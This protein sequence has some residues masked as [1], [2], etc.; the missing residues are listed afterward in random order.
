VSSIISAAGL[1]KE[2]RG[3]GSVAVDHI[4]FEVRDGECFGFLGPNGAGK[5]TTMRMIACRAQ[6]S[7]GDLTVMGLDPLRNERDIKAQMGVVPQE[8]NLDTVI[9]VEENLLMYARFFGIA[10][11]EGASRARELLE[12]VQLEDRADWHVDNLSGGMKRRLLIARSLV[13]RPRVIVLDEPTTGL[14]PQARHLVWER[15]RD[16]KRRGVTLVI[17]THYM[18][19]AAQLCD[20]LVIMHQGRILV[21]GSPTELIR[22]HVAPQVVELTARSHDALDV[23]EQEVIGFDVT[24]EVAGDRV[25]M[26]T[27]DGETLLKSIREAG[28]DFESATFRPANMEDVFL[29]MTGRRLE[30]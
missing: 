15:L 8:T 12:F 4:D 3:S 10:R 25:V 18:E 9:S 21:E 24:Y 20:R 13:N 16:L 19:E 22:R 11:S 2:Y 30:E 6:R 28:V 27:D 26:H 14:D 1:V 29:K 7:G 17:T 23:L 5:T